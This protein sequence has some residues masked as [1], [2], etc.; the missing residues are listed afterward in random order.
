[1]SELD[2][3]ELERHFLDLEEL[4]RLLLPADAAAAP[5]RGFRRAFEDDPADTAT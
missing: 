1:M 2:S 3:G 4:G 5:F